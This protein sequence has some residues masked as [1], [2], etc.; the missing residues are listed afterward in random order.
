MG[1]NQ[2]VNAKMKP[3][4]GIFNLCVLLSS[5]VGAHHFAGGS[6]VE[7]PQFFLQ[8]LIIGSLIWLMRNLQIDG[9]ALA[10]VAVITQSSGHFI[11][12]VSN[13]P[14]NVQMSLSHIVAGF[15]SYK[16][17]QESEHLWELI[18][19]LA[20]SI[21]LFFRPILNFYAQPSVLREKGVTHL[22]FLLFL[23]SNKYRGPPRLSEI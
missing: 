9:P 15:L 21:F 17:V 19:K 14:N 10:L 18:L 22:R 12:G 23:D 16:L 20:G 6:F 5:S 3:E 13:S 8:L 11:L 1:D 4:K 7:M 2:R